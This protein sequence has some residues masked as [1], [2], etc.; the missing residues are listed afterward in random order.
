MNSTAL[1]SLALLVIFV[2]PASAQ[3]V[4]RVRALY[5]QA[6]YEE[7]L[8]AIPSRAPAAVRL[9]IEQYRAL[10]LLALGREDEASTTVEAIVRENPTYLPSPTD[11][12]P[13]MQAIVSAARLKVLPDLARQVYAEGKAA[14]DARDGPAAAAA[15]TRA[16]AIVDSL[17]EAERGRLAD[18]RLLAAEFLDL[19]GERLA[20]P[21]AEKVPAVPPLAPAVTGPVPVEEALPAWYPPDATSLRAE[22]DGLLRI[23]IGPD[24]RVVSAE[25]VR[26]SHPAYDAAV[27]RAAKGWTYRPATRDGQPVSAR[28]DIQIRLVPR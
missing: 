3:D 11:V 17:P 24:G 7:A 2:A 21:A 23:E 18:L 26:G 14:F 25:I 10:C 9:E 4:Q 16:L 27:L 20:P 12:S 22:Y 19:A 28:K 8:A 13:R 15:F 1:S 5:V 6:A